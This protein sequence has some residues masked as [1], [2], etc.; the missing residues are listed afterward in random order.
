MRVTIH[1]P[2]YLPWLGYFDKIDQADCFVVLDNVQFKKNEWQNR[3]RIRTATGWQWLTVP[4]L[5]KFP[6]L[7]TE[8]GVDN[9]APWGRK[10]FQA[11]ISNYH[12][13]PF[14]ASHRPFFEDL[15]ARRW[16]RLVDLSLAALRYLITALGIETR[17][18]LA[19]E[20]TTEGT[21]TARLVSIC[22]ALGA[23]TYISGAGAHDYLDSGLFES[24][25]IRVEFQEFRCPKY[26]QQFDGFEPNLS[27]V[28][29][30]LNCGDD[31]LAVLRRA[32]PPR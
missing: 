12:A 20:L 19:S 32:R 31:A 30:L 16:D 28:D 15:Y 22:R 27:V 4:V 3:N 8:V 10:H 21:S 18:V 26:P 1:Q 6:Q 29:L 9:A 7:I 14:F 2:Q 11:L 17:V 25:G 5:H 13:A 23:D 24:A